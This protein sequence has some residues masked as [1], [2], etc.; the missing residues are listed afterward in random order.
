MICFIVFELVQYVGLKGGMQENSRYEK[1]KKYNTDLF[2]VR[3]IV[4]VQRH[5][6][7]LLIICCSFIFIYSHG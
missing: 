2:S 7:H 5:I 6:P 3:R 4:N 1:R